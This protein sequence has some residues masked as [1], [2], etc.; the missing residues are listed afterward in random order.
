MSQCPL[1]I[2]YDLVSLSQLFK[3]KLYFQPDFIKYQTVNR[4]K[5]IIKT[6]LKKTSRKQTYR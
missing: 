3:L 4:Q 1:E 2:D 6:T 5:C